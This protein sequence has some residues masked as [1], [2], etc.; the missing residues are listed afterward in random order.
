M[1]GIRLHPKYGVNPTIPVCFF[2]GKEKN[3][4]ALLGAAYQGEAPMRMVIDKVPCDWCQENMTKGIV[5]VEVEGQDE[6]RPTGGYWVIREEAA[7]R[8]LV[9]KVG[10]EI[11]RKRLGFIDRETATKL[12]LRDIP[13]T[14]SGK[15]TA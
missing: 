10:E 15:E 14:E 1:G 8:I 12:G 6:P 3:E 11:L 7:R 9:G 4:V 13:D 5:L 2:C